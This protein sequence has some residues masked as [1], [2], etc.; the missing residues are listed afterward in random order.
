MS[1]Y[2]VTTIETTRHRVVMSDPEANVPDMG[3]IS[4][5]YGLLRVA[6]AVIGFLCLV[7]IESTG[8][9]WGHSYHNYNFFASI[10]SF[11]MVFAI[12]V[13]IFFCFRV[14]EFLQRYINLPLSVSSW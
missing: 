7:L 8:P 12:I 11:S 3:F 5:R 10:A 13:M 1:A 14:Q 6:Q 4:T 2:Q 9:C